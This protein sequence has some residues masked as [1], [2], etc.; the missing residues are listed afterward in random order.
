MTKYREIKTLVHAENI[1][2]WHAVQSC[3]IN[4]PGMSFSMDGSLFRGDLNGEIFSA[5]LIFQKYKAP[6]IN[7]MKWLRLV[8]NFMLSEK[9]LIRRY[10]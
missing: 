6:D 2:F 4:I 3:M 7:G 10:C 8:F 5:M 9:R 1:V